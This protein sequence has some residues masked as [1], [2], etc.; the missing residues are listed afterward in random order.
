MIITSNTFSDKSS[1]YLSININCP[2]TR[3]SIKVE[4]KRYFLSFPEIVFNLL[5]YSCHN[6]KSY[7]LCC[8]MAY[9]I[10]ENYYIPIL[11]NMNGL[12][13]CLGFYHFLVDPNIHILNVNEIANKFL[14]YFWNSSFNDD[15]NY[16]FYCNPEH[17]YMHW[18]TDTLKDVNWIPE[19][20]TF[21]LSDISPEEYGKRALSIFPVN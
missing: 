21:A 14:N 3:R 17:F 1:D 13:V 5:I 12:S 7:D 10:D 6:A 4:D 2:P 11:S 18:Q 16:N 9:K 20:N 19:K 8:F 15:L